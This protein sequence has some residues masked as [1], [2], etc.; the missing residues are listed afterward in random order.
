MGDEGPA[1]RKGGGER[2]KEA[3]GVEGE[4]GPRGNG[5]RVLASR[6]VGGMVGKEGKY[7]GNKLAFGRR[8]GSCNVKSVSSS[9]LGHLLPV[10]FAP[11]RSSEQCG[12]LESLPVEVDAYA[13]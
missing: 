7:R 4:G 2:S 9:S 13:S 5:E 12:L 8:S 10:C 3:G 6:G 11:W 1:D